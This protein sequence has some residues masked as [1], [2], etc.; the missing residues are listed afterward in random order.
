MM[1]TSSQQ[2]T[3][4]MTGCR[5]ST[6]LRS[7]AYNDG[8]QFSTTDNRGARPGWVVV[9]AGMR[10]GQSKWCVLPH[11]QDHRYHWDFLGVLAWWSIFPKSNNYDDTEDMRTAE[12]L[13][14]QRFTA[15]VYI[16]PVSPDYVT[17]LVRSRFFV[18][19]SY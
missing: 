17:A 7:A 11:T 8:N 10:P 1:V 12:K 5:Q 3:E 4:T 6:V 15:I 18:S 16:L 2:P 13:R 14:Y 9:S 19:F